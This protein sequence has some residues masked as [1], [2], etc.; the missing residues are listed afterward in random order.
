MKIPATL[1]LNSTFTG[2]A[3]LGENLL[4]ETLIKFALM[5]VIWIPVHFAW[6]YAGANLKRLELPDR[7]QRM[8][9][10]LMALAMLLVVVLALVS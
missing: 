5:N 3:F 6:L 7:T 2:F 10:I 9:N 8:I 4:A 1:R